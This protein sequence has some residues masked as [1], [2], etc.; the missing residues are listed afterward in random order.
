MSEEFVTNLLAFKGIVI[1]LWMAAFFLAERFWPA[2]DCA[3]PPNQRPLR[4]LRNLVLFLM[5]AGLSPL[6]VV[7][8]TGFA[9]LNSLDWRPDWW[10]GA[11]GLVLD[12]LLLDFFIYWWHR[13][14][15]EIP[16]L[17]RFHQ[18]HHYDRFLDSTTAVRFHF[19]EVILSAFV[20]GG[21]IIAMGIPLVS[22][23]IFEG[24]V[25]IS[26]IFQ[27]SNIRLAP[28][29][30]RALSW[31][32]VTPGWH[33][34]HH[35]AI[36]EDTDSNYANTLTIWDRLFRS[37]CRHRRRLTM[38]IGLEDTLGDLSF[39]RLLQRP[40]LVRAPSGRRPGAGSRD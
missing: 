29:L 23:L 21:F 6:I 4:V 22:V 9:A 14:N 27:H 17:W 33:W 37:A 11:G 32:I 12:L 24:L 10:G 2:A 31:I 1:L 18:V 26:S 20:R 28:T 15:H 34:M 36:R 40:F 38:P 13:A 30:D 3:L 35:H 5:N 19:G 25:L 16:F 39:W 8:V 7:P